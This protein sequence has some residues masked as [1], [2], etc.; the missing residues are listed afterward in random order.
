MPH[1]TGKNHPQY[2]HGHAKTRLYQMW[3][4][5]RQRCTN[6]K[7]EKYSLYG[8]RG[9][10]VHPTWDDFATF[11]AWAQAN[12]YQQGLSIERV[13]N[14]GNY[15]P[16]NCIWT[17]QKVQQRNRRDNR[18]VIRSDGRIYGNMADAAEDTGNR[19]CKQNIWHTCNGNQKT[20]G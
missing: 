5:M 19:C 20:S 3:S 18:P 17:T 1:P 2:R 12:G 13:D 6:P 8:A 7:D 11:L 14:T 10:M 15:E 16:D 4:K 9:I